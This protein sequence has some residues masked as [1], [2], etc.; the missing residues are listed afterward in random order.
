MKFTIVFV[1]ISLTLLLFEESSPSNNPQEDKR[2]ECNN[3][4]KL[5]PKAEVPYEISQDFIGET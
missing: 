3:G 2:T 5:W 1:I 4:G